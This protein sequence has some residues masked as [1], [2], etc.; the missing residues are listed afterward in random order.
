MITAV[1]QLSSLTQN[2]H[3]RPPVKP[4]RRQKASTIG[5]V[6][7]EDS[8]TF[9]NDVSVTKTADDCSTRINVVSIGYMIN[10]GTYRLKAAAFKA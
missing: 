2:S 7:F 4:A 3:V 5:F 1:S 9:H 8:L 6:M 10:N